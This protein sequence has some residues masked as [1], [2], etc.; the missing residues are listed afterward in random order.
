M[1]T[2]EVIKALLERRSIRRFSPEAVAEDDLQTIITAGL[3]APSARNT[4]AWWATAVVGHDK[5]ARLNAA[6][7]VAT[8]LPGFDKYKGMADSPTYTINYKD[9]P[10]FIIV[11]VDPARSFAPRED[12][13]LVLSNMML[14]AHALGLGSC[15]INQ[16]GPIGDEPGFRKVLTALGVPAT[17]QVIGCLAV[18]HRAGDNPLPPARKPGGFNITS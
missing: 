6:V 8:P 17:Y 10:V 13:A 2:N 3:Y 4:Q 12:G 18:G 15:W 9:A 7:K 14:A 16:L 1:K 5:I 11:S